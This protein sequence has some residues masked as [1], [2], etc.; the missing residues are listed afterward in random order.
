MWWRWRS[1]R[2]MATVWVEL[3]LRLLELPVPE[4][5]LPVPEATIHAIAD[6]ILQAIV[7][8]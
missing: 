8:V 1:S 3:R 2:G 5:K 7:N 4:A 6:L